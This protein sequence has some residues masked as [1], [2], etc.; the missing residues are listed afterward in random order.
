MD[1]YDAALIQ[2]TANDGNAPTPPE[3]P[4]DKEVNNLVSGISS[5]WSGVAQK[6]S[7][8]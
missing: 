2:Q 5:W 3:T 1:I 4:L 7:L 6:V 8:P